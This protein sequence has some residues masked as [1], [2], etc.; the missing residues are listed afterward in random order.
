MG[1][2]RVKTKNPVLLIGSTY[3]PVTPIASAHNVSAGFEG[4][5]VLERGGFGVSFHFGHDASISTTD[6]S[7]AC[8]HQPEVHLRGEGSGGLLY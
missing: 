6:P 3:D 8:F 2:F 4:S 1:D 7:V 5:V